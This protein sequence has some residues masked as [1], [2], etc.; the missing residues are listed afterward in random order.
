[1]G[2]LTTLSQLML[3]ASSSVALDPVGSSHSAASTYTGHRIKW[4]PCTD[5]EPDTPVKCGVLKVPYDYT[6]P[7]SNR[8]Y[9]L[10]VVKFAAAKKPS[11]GTVFVNFGGPGASGKAVFAE[12]S[13]RLQV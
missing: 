12:Y 10:E 7:R 2:L 5:L 13:K 4:H 9:D 8:L 11:K 6:K 3:V 1:M